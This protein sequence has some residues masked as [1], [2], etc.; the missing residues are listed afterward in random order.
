MSGGRRARERADAAA[1]VAVR[2]AAAA[3]AGVPPGA[4][5]WAR[6]RR[7]FRRRAL[8]WGLLIGHVLREWS[9]HGV[10]A[11]V[12]SPARRALRVGRRFGDDTLAYFTERLDPAPTRAALAATVRRAKRNKA[13]ETAALDRAGGRRDG[14]RARPHGGLCVCHPRARRRGQA[15]ATSITG[16]W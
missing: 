2:A 8:L 7:R 9:F 12:R 13:F 10:E 3:A 1:A 16:V 11:L 6:A 15:A 5:R 14:G 4:G